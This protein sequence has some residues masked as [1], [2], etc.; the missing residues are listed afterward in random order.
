MPNLPIHPFLCLLINRSRVTSPCH[1]MKQHSSLSSL[2]SIPPPEKCPLHLG[3]IQDAYPLPC[4]HTA[5]QECLHAIA[6]VSTLQRRRDVR[7]PVCQLDFPFDPERRELE[8]AQSRAENCG[9]TSRSGSRSSSIL[10]PVN[11]PLMRRYSVKIKEEIDT[12]ASKLGV[13][14]DSKVHKRVTLK[15]KLC[16]K[17]Q[18]VVVPNNNT[19]VT[20]TITS[21]DNQQTEISLLPVEDAKDGE[22]SHSF[23]KLL[24]PDQIGKYRVEVGLVGS[25][26]KRILADVLIKPSGGKVCVLRGSP[27]FK[28]PHDILVTSGQYV[29]TDKCHHKVVVVDRDGNTVSEFGS[30]PPKGLKKIGPFAVIG[31]PHAFYVTD[32][33][34]K[35]VLQF[36]RKTGKLSK[37]AN[38]GRCP[39]GIAL[40]TEKIYVA[41][42]REHNIRIFNRHAD[43]LSKMSYQGTLQGAVS[44]P[45]FMKINSK[46]LLVVADKNNCRIQVF[47]PRQQKSVQVISLNLGGKRWHCR[48]ITVDRFDNIYATARRVDSWRG[49]SRETIMVFSPDGDFL[50]NFGELRE[51]DYLRGIAIDDSQQMA[52]VV[53]GA[54]HVIKGFRL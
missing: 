42:A 41:D 10:S 24:V 25:V 43:L 7:C 27:K 39:T 47:D 18:R 21:P 4:G 23:E 29:I 48:G 6:S 1:I 44:F 54:N 33:I 34:N 40:D 14:H 28:N 53:D 12:D 19:F 52:M 38:V 49:C 17:N 45:W 30:K 26:R 15:L 46:G 2:S 50:G 32:D 9:R 5:C 31:D 22:P 11:N 13:S 35:C 37:W 36:I 20:G 16:D 51:F 3:Q 8:E